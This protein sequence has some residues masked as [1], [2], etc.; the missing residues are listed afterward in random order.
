MNLILIIT[1]QEFRVNIYFIK[2]IEI[3]IFTIINISCI[4]QY[5]I[6][7]WQSQG[8]KNVFS[9]HFRKVEIMKEINNLTDYV[10]IANV[11]ETNA[12]KVYI[13]YKGENTLDNLYVINEFEYDK[14]DLYFFKKLFNVFH[15]P[16]K[17][18]EFCDFFVEKEKFYAVYKYNEAPNIKKLYN[19]EL[20]VTA[21]DDRCKMLELI[22]IQIDK[23]IKFPYEIVGCVS[24]FENIKIDEDKNIHLTYNFSHISKYRG[25]NLNTIFENLREII[26]NLLPAECDAPFN[27]QLHIVLE[28]C[29]NGVYRSIPEL[30]I[31][32]KHAEEISKTSSWLQY[33]K[34]QLS[35]RKSLLSRI[36]KASVWCLLIFGVLYLA[37][38]KLTEGRK[39]NENAPK[40]T[41]GNISYNG[42]KEDESEKTVSTENQDNQTNTKATSD[43]I[44]SKGLD[45]EYEDYIVQQGDTVSSICNEYYKE[46]R[47]ETAIATFNGIE[48]DS[49]LTPGTILKLPNRTAIAMYISK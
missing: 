3:Y 8:F 28:K 6:T 42:N 33:I 29:K 48:V 14:A 15:S 47:Y 16:K 21:F 46:K 43:I 32:L 49:K 17:P 9:L 44:L 38:S 26:Y 7:C 22:L 20:S 27:K 35:L 34:Y 12:C 36:S 11:S 45:M 13:A 30:I 10:I 5:I 19:K 24:E 39:S 37:Y 40:V 4:I 18:K 41:I 1:L 31:E 23:L 25:C 2:I